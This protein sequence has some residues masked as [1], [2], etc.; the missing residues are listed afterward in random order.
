METVDSR[1]AMMIAVLSASKVFRP[2]WTILS[3]GISNELVASSK[4]NTAGLAI[5]ALAKEIS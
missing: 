5:K 1:C 3:E 4:I 2:C